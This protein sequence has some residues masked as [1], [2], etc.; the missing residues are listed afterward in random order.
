MQTKVENCDYALIDFGAGRKLERF[1]QLILDRCSPAAEGTA[2]QQPEIWGSADI[3]LDEHGQITHGTQP[4]HTW[5]VIVSGL[6]FSL[7]ITPFGHVGIFP[8]QHGNWNWLQNLPTNLR[9]SEPQQ[10]LNLFAYTGGSTIALAKAGFQVVHVDASAPAVRWAREN[11]ALNHLQD[12]PVRW[13]V[14]D[15]RKFT[16]R[17]IKR[18]HRYDVIVLDPPSFGHGLSGTRWEIEQHLFPL[19]ETCIQLLRDGHATLLLTGH[20]ETPSVPQI[21]SWLDTQT[22]HCGHIS[23]Q[24][25]ALLDANRRSLDCGYSLR[26]HSQLSVL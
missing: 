10:A 4:Q 19:L 16:A 18:G 24:R 5:Q 11:A 23:T 21:A 12:A 8:E 22:H 13:I 7:A 15:V 14:D 2:R 25:L 9:N 3:R 20:S 26:W 1:G 17:E 6:R